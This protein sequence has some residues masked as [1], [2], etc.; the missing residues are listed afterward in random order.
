MSSTE[1]EIY[2]DAPLASSEE[3]NDFHEFREVEFNLEDFGDDSIDAMDQ[4]GNNFNENLYGSLEDL[5][6]T[7]DEKIT[8][9]FRNYEEK[10]EKFA[11]VQ[12]RSHEEIVND[13]QLW[14]TITGNFG[15]ILPIDWSKTYA[16]ELQAKALNLKGPTE[17]KPMNLDLSD[18][19]EL[20]RSFDMH[21][22][23]ISCLQDE[24][25]ATADDVINEIE[26]MMGDRCNSPSDIDM[27][28]PTSNL[29]YRMKNELELLQ[30]EDIQ[31]MSMKQ[32]NELLLDTEV[33][34]KEYS[35]T[36]IEEL[37]L[38]DELEFEKEL[39]NQFI[40]LLLGIQRRKRESQLQDKKKNK[41]NK[42]IT[43]NGNET[44]NTTT[45][46]LSTVIPYH[47]NVGVPSSEQL[48]YYIKIMK[49]IMDNNKQVPSL[50]TDYI[51]T[52]LCPT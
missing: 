20:T 38:R 11:P 2:S 43:D 19:E 40:S 50:L 18:D 32:L 16:R 34:V 23:I 39:K 29:H 49:A 5:V 27:I 31:K 36:L 13:C 24:P 22:I 45:S 52:V 47:A 14:W 48:H 26:D 44:T 8:M 21:S 42:H 35:E 30:Y 1:L 15:N 9:C 4:S 37:A 28:S 51:L 7:F 17:V 12:F 41:K 10:V 25:L 6:N 33:M 46:F 3:W